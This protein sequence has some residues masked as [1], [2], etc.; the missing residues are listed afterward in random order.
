METELAEQWLGH[1]EALSVEIEHAMHS[2]AG[3]ALEKLEASVRRQQVL[4][5]NLRSAAAE[6]PQLSRSG[7][8]SGLSGART[9]SA[10]SQGVLEARI[11]GAR[12]RLVQLGRTYAIL[13]QHSGQSLRMLSAF[14][15]S[16]GEPWKLAGNHAPSQTWSCQG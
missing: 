4:C 7:S 5:A 15:A 11:A 13:L 1:V 16:Q 6:L 12:E 2:I 3:N 10:Q 14:Y 9:G 8:S